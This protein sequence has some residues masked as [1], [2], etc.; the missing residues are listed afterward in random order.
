M[1]APPVQYP[2][3]FTAFTADPLHKETLAEAPAKA[4]AGAA[5]I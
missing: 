3:W 5:G 2:A 1:T 4:A